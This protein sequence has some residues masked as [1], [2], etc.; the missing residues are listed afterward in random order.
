[1]IMF[2]NALNFSAYKPSDTRMISNRLTG[3][4]VKRSGSD[5][6]WGIIMFAWEDRKTT[7]SHQDMIVGHRAN[8]W[9][10]HFPNTK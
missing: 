2:I 3:K 7:K 10:R 9:T 6:I 4:G 8:I 5:Q 1:M